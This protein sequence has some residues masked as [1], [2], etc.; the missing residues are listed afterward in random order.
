VKCYIGLRGC[1]GSGINTFDCPD[2]KQSVCGVCHAPVKSDN[3]I[4]TYQPLLPK[5]RGPQYMTAVDA[6]NDVAVDIL[7]GMGIDMPSKEQVN[8]MTMA[9]G[10]LFQVNRLPLGYHVIG[11]GY[12]IQIRK[13]TI[14][15]YEALPEWGGY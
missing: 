7:D 4:R 9:L 13:M 8:M 10:H 11:S 2:E 6:M 15:E 3:T 1:D 12:A 14:V 5:G